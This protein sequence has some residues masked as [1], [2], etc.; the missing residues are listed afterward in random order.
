[1]IQLSLL[2]ACAIVLHI[3]ET[4]L[5]VIQIFF[6]PGVKLGL[7]NIITL[8]ALIIFGFRESVSVVALRSILA[9]LLIGTFFSVT[10]FLSL[11]GALGSSMVMGIIYTLGK[12][13]FS[14][15]VI[16]VL[17]AIFHNISQLLL[18]SVLISQIE[19]FVYLPYLLLF[20]VPTGL[21]VGLVVKYLLIKVE[22]R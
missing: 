19:I 5:P 20:S 4:M 15:V 17:G 2:I 3:I 12:N 18:A 13:Y 8:L 11:A 9:S 21:F 10:F 16:S 14:I 6:L 7:A 1:M 22:F